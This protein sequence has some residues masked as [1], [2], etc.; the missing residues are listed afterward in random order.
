MFTG[1][2]VE[3]EKGGE[4]EEG[5]GAGGVCVCVCGGGGGQPAHSNHHRGGRRGRAG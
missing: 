4:G 2:G 3:T 1:G 5:V